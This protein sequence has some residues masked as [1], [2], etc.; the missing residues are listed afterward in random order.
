MAAQMEAIATNSVSPLKLFSGDNVH[1][2]DGIVL[3]DGWSSLRTG[4]RQP[5]GMT[6]PTRILPLMLNE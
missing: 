1:T 6:N 2:E 4:R 5:I 3:T